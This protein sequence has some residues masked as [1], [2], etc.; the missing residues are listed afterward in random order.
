M[1]ARTI[2]VLH[3]RTTSQYADIFTKGLPT[4]V[5]FEFQSSLNVQPVD[6]AIA[7][8][9]SISHVYRM[10]SFFRPVLPISLPGMFL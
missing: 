7:E 4:D 8:G 5:F 10:F 9:V 2:Q 6:V 1:T 3:V